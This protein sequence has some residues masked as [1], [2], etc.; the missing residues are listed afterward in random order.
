VSDDSRGWMIGLSRCCARG[1][2]RGSI[3]LGSFKYKSR[4]LEF[5]DEGFFL[6]RVLGTSIKKNW[7]LIWQ[8]FSGLC[9]YVRSYHKKNQDFWSFGL[10]WPSIFVFTKE[11]S[12]NTKESSPL[13]HFCSH[14]RQDGQIDLP[15][16]PFTF[17]LR[18]PEN[19]HIVPI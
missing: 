13:D 14:L 19:T 8:F 17:L 6:C 10:A 5:V 11:F 15:S 4:K 12:N 1:W 2:V 16:S 7:L 9:L 3:L 18:F